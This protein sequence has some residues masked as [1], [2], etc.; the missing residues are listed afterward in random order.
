[1]G[2]RILEGQRINEGDRPGAVFYDSTDGRAFGPVFDS[3]EEAEKFTKFVGNFDPRELLWGDELSAGERLYRLWL[4]CGR[5][6]R[7]PPVQLDES[8]IHKNKDD[9]G[10]DEWGISC[11]L[12]E[13]CFPLFNGFNNNEV[14]EILRKQKVIPRGGDV[15]GD[16][17]DHDETFDT[18]FSCFYAYFKTEKAAQQFL[19]RLNAWLRENWH[20]AYPSE[21]KPK[22]RKTKRTAKMPS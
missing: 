6:A 10:K 2:T 11:S 19:W 16:E 17:E 18:E 1:M 8:Y 21:E 13:H 3:A 20:R 22:K 5:V 9:H 12:V 4:A 15:G 7:R 14:A